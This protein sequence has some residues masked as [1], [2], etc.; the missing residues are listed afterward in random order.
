MKDSHYH[1]KSNWQNELLQFLFDI[2]ELEPSDKVLKTSV[3]VLKKICM[4]KEVE[5]KDFEL[6]TIKV[7]EDEPDEVLA[8]CSY[9]L[10]L[11]EKSND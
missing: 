3:S 5:L 9:I 2:E 1:N 8:K 11:Y 7:C 10:R 4:E 6:E